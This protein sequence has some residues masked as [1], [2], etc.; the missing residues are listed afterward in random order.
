MD[1][2]IVVFIDPLIIP[3]YLPASYLGGWREGCLV[4]CCIPSTWH[5]VELTHTKNVL[6]E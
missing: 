3:V 2:Y 6:N 4:N 5:I 1:K